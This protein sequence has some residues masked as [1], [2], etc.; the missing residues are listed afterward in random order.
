MKD[1]RNINIRFNLDDPLHKKAWVYL[2]T[3]DRKAFKSYSSAVITALV[4]FFDRY[5]KKKDDP[6]FE[7]RESEER[8]VD[9]IVEEVGKNIK[10]YFSELTINGSIETSKQKIIE[11]VQEEIEE[12]ADIDWSFIGK[13]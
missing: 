13:G 11:D 4:D 5:N 10:I 3:M 6:Y 2:H 12:N 8:F 1:I 7:T 9:R